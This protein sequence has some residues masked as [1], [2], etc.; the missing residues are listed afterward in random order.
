MR[1]KTRGC[2]W[3]AFKAWKFFKITQIF[4]KCV[5]ITRGTV[6]IVYEQNRKIMTSS[7]TGLKIA[8]KFQNCRRKLKL[9]S[10]GAES[11]ADS[12]NI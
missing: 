5:G 1:E 7:N 4:F 6:G 10:N 9:V 11:Q 12:E 8:T 2:R 3:D